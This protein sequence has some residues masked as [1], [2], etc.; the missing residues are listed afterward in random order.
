[1]MRRRQLGFTLMEVMIGLALLGVALTVLI[2]SAA[3][4]IFSARQAQM[5][6]IATDLARGKL[7]DIEEI[8][9]KDGYTETDQ[10][11]GDIGEPEKGS[12]ARWTK[13]RSGKCLIRGLAEHFTTVSREQC[14]SD[15]Q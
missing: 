8:L 15:M 12:N 13:A 9:L 14:E 7:N 11:E 1:M 3:S 2:K 4:S 6:G 10:S 5:M